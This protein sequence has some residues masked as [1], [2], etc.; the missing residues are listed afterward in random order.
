MM[1]ALTQLVLMEVADAPVFLTDLVDMDADD[2]T[3]VVWHCGQAPISMRDPDVQPTATIHT[4]RRM[5]L[6]FEFPLK[7]GRVTFMRLSQAFGETKMVVATGEM[8]KRPMAFTGTSGV[9]RFDGGTARTLDRIIAA[10]LEHHM[11]LA[12]GDH[13]AELADVAAAMGLPLLEL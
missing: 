8:L 5:P 3:G 1:G 9:V 4:N 13:T 12:Y 11:A 6:L 7:P 10:G 2:D